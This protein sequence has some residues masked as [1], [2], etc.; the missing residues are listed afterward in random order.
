MSG[1]SRSAGPALA[2]A[3]AL[4][5]GACGSAPPPASSSAPP[6]ASSSAPPSA[7]PPAR[8][9]VLIV[10]DQLPSWSF[11]ALSPTLRA[12]FRRLLDHGVY[13]PR[14]QLPYGVPLTAP[15]HATLAT[16]APPAVHGVLGNSWYRRA[17]KLV[18]DA[19]EDPRSPIFQLAPSPGQAAVLSSGSSSV[20]LRVP[21]LAEALHQGTG[22]RGQA[23]AIGLKARA[24][25]FVAGQHPDEVIFFEP[26]AGGMTTSTAYAAAIPPWLVAHAAAFPMSRHLGAQWHPLNE[27]RLR[28]VTG[29][30]DAAPGEG[31]EHQLGEVFPHQLAKS[32]SPGKAL[33]L[34]PFGD[35][36]VLEAARAAVTRRRLGADEVPD[37]LALSLNSHDFTGHSFGQ[38]SWE[39]VDLLWRLDAELGAL[40]TFLDE[41]VGAEHYAVVLTSD[42][43]ATPLVERGGVPG[44][45]RIPPVEI[46]RVAE[47][48]FDAAAGAGDWVADLSSSNLYLTA[49]GR[50]LD[51]PLRARAL[52]ATAEAISQIPGVLAAGRYEPILGAVP[53]DCPRGSALE[54]AMCLSAAPGE[55]GELYVV[56]RPGSLITSFRTGTHHDAPSDDNRQVPLLV[57]APGVAA[58][59]EP[60]VITNLQVA[61]TVAALLGVPPPSAARAA[62][63]VLRAPSASAPSAP[64]APVR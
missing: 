22:G 14:L 52:D 64:S 21:G 40:F 33:A 36:L 61:P 31:G 11:A 37:L 53:G 9:V 38:G 17:S 18:V 13:V 35:Q 32:S 58:R 30:E 50:A 51:A 54:R 56:P 6:S 8:L 55:H 49:A 23:V 48:A 1:A 63:L 24:A 43:G 10:V 45:R 57:M 19:D 27:A 25:C 39:Q 60:G 15:G 4:L 34:T 44:A 62:A 41:Q 12:G 2:L 42:H 29:V 3:G 16:G 7:P 47:A 28:T 46:L 59:T 5:V 26:D 20:A